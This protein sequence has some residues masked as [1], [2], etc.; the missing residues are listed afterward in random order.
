MKLKVIL[1]GL[2]IGVFANISFGATESYVLDPLHTAVN[3]EINHFGFANVTGK[4]YADGQ[5]NYDEQ[6]PQNSSVKVTIDIAK[7]VTGIPKLDYNMLGSAFLDVKKY[8][9]ATFVSTKVTMMDKNTGTVEGNLT[10][11][12]VTKPVVLNVTFNKVGI[13]PITKLNTSGFSAK[14]SIMRSDYKITTYVPS[15]SDEVQLDIE[16]EAMINKGK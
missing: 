12:G 11:H 3:W 9:K 14:T 6:N 2:L 15:I 13:D 4:W 5:L 1:L 8:P 10:L 7:I 16:V